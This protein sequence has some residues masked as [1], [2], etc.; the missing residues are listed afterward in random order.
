MQQS[1]V[2][3]VGLSPWKENLPQM[4]TVILRLDLIS[5]DIKV[6]AEYDYQM[7]TGDG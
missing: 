2:F 1:A 4:Q 3:L 5:P 6:S 7:K